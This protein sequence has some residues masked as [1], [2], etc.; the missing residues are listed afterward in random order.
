MN[1]AQWTR[2]QPCAICETPPPS[3]WSHVRT[4]GNSGTGIKPDDEFTIPACHDCHVMETNKGRA[5]TLMVK[6]NL[7]LSRN[8]AKYFY[9][10]L[11]AEHQKRWL[12]TQ[13]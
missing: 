5:Y 8:D 6:K 2:K 13:R 12:L 9:L 7:T 10:D 3:E 11:A 4:A 1:K